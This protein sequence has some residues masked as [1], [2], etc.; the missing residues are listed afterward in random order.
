MKSLFVSC[1]APFVIAD[2]AKKINDSK[3]HALAFSSGD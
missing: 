1:L 3:C 2:D